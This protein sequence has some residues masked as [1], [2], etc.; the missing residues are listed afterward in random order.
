VPLLDVSEVLDDPDFSDDSLICLRNPQTVGADGRAVTTQVS[1]AFAGV[2]TAA[3]GADLVRGPD[4]EYV[5]SSICIVTRFALI[6]GK[7]GFSADT[8][9]W[10][11]GVYTVVH[12]D[13]YSRYGDGFTQAIADLKPLSG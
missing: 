6:D 2:V 5:R 12:A 11:G 8:V 13:D 9:Q 10:N 4:G 3:S 1:I 7:R